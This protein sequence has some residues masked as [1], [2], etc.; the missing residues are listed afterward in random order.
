[1]TAAKKQPSPTRPS[2]K[3]EN[4]LIPEIVKMPEKPSSGSRDSFGVNGKLLS[5]GHAYPLAGLT[6]QAVFIDPASVDGAE[7]NQRR[8]R[9]TMI[10]A[11]DSGQGGE[12]RI[13]FFET[14][15]AQ[16]KLRLLQ[17]SL[18]GCLVLKVQAL[19]ARSEAGSERGKTSPRLYYVSEKFHSPIQNPLTLEIPLERK[20]ILPGKWKEFAS[21]LK[22][23]RLSAL[24]IIAG[25]LLPGR[26]AGS[27]FRDWDLETRFSLLE[28]LESA[29]L[30]PGGE[31]QKAGFEPAF[32]NFTNPASLAADKKRLQKSSEHLR[33]V[34]K[35]SAARA[36]SYGGIQAVDTKVDLDDLAKGS[37]SDA[38]NKYA[39][40]LYDPLDL[41]DLAMAQGE[42]PESL[43]PYRDYLLTLFTSSPILDVAV[44]ENGTIEN[45]FHQDFRTTSLGLIPVNALLIPFVRE[46]LTSKTGS[47]FG[48][49][50]SPDSLPAK[51]GMTNREYLDTLIGLSGLTANEF[52]LRYR[53]NLGRPESALSCPVAENIATLQGFYRDGFQDLLEPDPIY[54]ADKS[55]RAPFFLQYDE[56][57]RYLAPFYGENFYNAKHPFVIDELDATQRNAL[58]KSASGPFVSNSKWRPAQWLLNFLEIQSKVME[59]HKAYDL[60]QYGIA[61][62]L[63]KQAG[64]MAERFLINALSYEEKPQGSNNPVSALVERLHTLLLQKKNWSILSMQDLNR[65]EDS[66][67]VQ[68]GLDYS[69]TMDVWLEIKDRA[70][71]L[72]FRFLQ[73]MLYQI[74]L[75][76][77]DCA[78]AMGDYEEAV[79]Q[80]SNFSPLSL[81]HALAEDFLG[82]DEFPIGSPHTPHLVHDE[83]SDSYSYSSEVNLLFNRGSLPYTLSHNAQAR[84]EA[85]YAYPDT[86]RDNNYGADLA[87]L[88][89]PAF[90][91]PMEERFYRLRLASALLEWADVLYRTNEPGNIARARELYKGVYWVHYN[92]PPIFPNWPHEG[93]SPATP[94]NRNPA[95][96]SQLLCAQRGFYQ[97]EA[98]L[99]YYGCSEEI[100]P[101]QRYSTLKQAADHFAASAQA[102]QKDFLV[103]MANI[104]KILEQTLRDDLVN[105][106][107][108][109]KALLQAKIAGEQTE[110][111]R[112]GVVQSEQQVEAVQAAILAKEKEMADHDS[113]LGQFSDFCSGFKSALEGLG[114]AK[115]A[116]NFPKETGGIAAW[117]AT[118][119]PMVGFVIF[120]YAG[121]TSMSSMTDEYNR[122]RGEWL[123][124]RDQTLPRAKAQVMVKQREVTIANLQGLI[125]Q[126][127]A[128]LARSLSA[129]LHEFQRDRFL[130]REF[131]GK[132]A[133]L[134]K[135][136]M[137]RYLEMGASYAWMAERALAYEQDRPINL[138]RLNYFP[139]GLQGVSGADLLQMD[140][141][142]L[143]AARL[144]NL[145]QTVPVKRVYSL[146]QDFP[147]AYGQF[148]KAGRCTFRTEEEP[149]RLAY[150]GVY[151]YRIRAVSLEVVSATPTSKPR[152]LLVNQG[153]SLISRPDGTSHDSLRFPE[154][155]PFSDFR[156]R[157]DMAVYGLP[158]ECLYNFEGSGLDTFWDLE[159]SPLGNSSGLD[160]VADILIT[161]DLRANYSAA[162]H[163]QQLE[164][165]PKTA[166]RMAMLSARRFQPQ[167]WQ[168]LIDGKTVSLAFNLAEI[169]MPGLETGRKITN[170]IFL[171]PG[172]ESAV[173]QAKLRWGAAHTLTAFGF[174]DGMAFSK[175]KLFAESKMEPSPLDALL[176]KD[177][178]QSLDVIIDPLDNPGVDFSK[179]NDLVLGVEYTV[180]Y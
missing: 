72:Q 17:N 93:M 25:Q 33:N 155:A 28:A 3:P 54:P 98:G 78:M 20:T 77:G 139:A 171:L 110:V 147:L 157:D 175:A 71:Y 55:D 42:A 50:I 178:M 40:E 143:E 53:L 122:L 148:K 149:F 135:R 138:V 150:P 92:K 24:H 117:G 79:R 51:A 10:G 108:L 62:T 95:I 177:A 172:G 70:T 145:K 102:S 159:F 161:F 52:G 89:I 5:A 86:N 116:A 167:E 39:S 120:V 88:I 156:L 23:A 170:L 180:K 73:Q 49:G 45:R 105:A 26:A 41:S 100:V 22:R 137:R 176:G 104:E 56:W 29:F 68:L 121:Y 11:G 146:V 13:T 154:A 34:Y 118:S 46:I 131:W 15:L 30:D 112:A 57:L 158:D 84:K 141:S 128:D 127:D 38:V 164:A 69:Y 152:G 160:N 85:G 31:L 37:L 19:A 16:Q 14:P 166:D 80:Y 64:L 169:G 8:P 12:F 179:I 132:L 142:E 101:A 76:L 44:D 83:K 63:Y 106:N 65:F 109:Q 4:E 81:G 48:F 9:E 134:M 144:D 111:A 136:V 18:Q 140:L 151:G 43:I 153:Y 126:T 133:A 130:N 119:G 129:S 67:V 27:L 47:G 125:A 94:Q 91:H 99:N 114:G 1:M 21:L 35:N 173:V 59:G 7:Q 2:I 168:A 90:T 74:P 96:R 82:Y 123:T 75:C 163:K 162:L 124:L 60:G 36:A 103:Y 32:C 87:R 58:V 66:F 115:D 107:M 174:V 97:I 61:R 6:V 165:Q 113:F